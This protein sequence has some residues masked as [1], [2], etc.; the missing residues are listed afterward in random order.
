MK[1]QT[2]AIIAT[3]CVVAELSLLGQQR[4]MP[5]TV[6][7]IVTDAISARP[8]A[9]ASIT[10]FGVRA[11]T[12]VRPPILTTAEGHFV[13]KDIPFDRDGINGQVSKPGY[14]TRKFTFS[15]KPGEHIRNAQI[16]LT[17]KAVA[18]GVISG[19]LI[20]QD[21]SPAVNVEL[22]LLPSDRPGPIY[23][24][25]NGTDDR[26]QYRIIS[27]PPGSYFLSFASRPR[28]PAFLGSF[29]PPDPLDIGPVLYPGVT[30]VS[31]AVIVEVRAGEETRLNTVTLNPLLRPGA[32]RFRIIN[33][34]GG[35]P[36]PKIDFG[37][38]RTT[39]PIGA[40]T[41]GPFGF[42]GTFV[43]A[44]GSIV[45][46]I[47]RTYW[48]R[49]TGTYSVTVGWQMQDANKT[50]V[51]VS[52]LVDFVGTDIDVDLRV[53]KPAAGSRVP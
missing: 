30:E 20:R 11:Q 51:S 23:G 44:D 3:F 27:L 4:L 22:N 47:T 24:S 46:E 40:S 21:G 36:P 34:T 25:S 15:P 5:S 18:T 17:P 53:V 13:L 12:A 14:A 41:G 16:T 49:L 32:I 28:P 2:A 43:Q 10:I 31:K 38:A 8:L 48:P 37:I 26:G 52:R 7:G 6:E 45:T 29:Q 35:L 39:A 42:D 50:A 33:D 19:R 1:M 9:D